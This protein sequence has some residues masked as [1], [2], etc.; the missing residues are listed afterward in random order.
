MKRRIT[1]S[2]VIIPLLASVIFLGFIT[3]C[4]T[5]FIKV[6]LVPKPVKRIINWFVEPPV[7]I[8]RLVLNSDKDRD[9]INDLEDIVKGARKEVQNKPKY[10][11]VYY[12]G[13]YPPQHE[14]VCTDVIW[15]ALENAGY[16]L[17]NLIDKDIRENT[18]DYPRVNGK[19]DPN[20]DFR[21][22]KNLEVFFEKYASGLTVEIRP[23]DIDNLKQW[24]GGDIVVFRSPE[25][26]GI[27]SDKRRRDGVP[28]VLHNGGPYASESDILLSA[29]DKITGHFRFPGK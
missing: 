24:Q 1:P 22:V 27:V 12:K 26:I 7:T 20:I 10:K 14:G 21:R 28:Y 15:R 16:D 18:G 2:V 17:K 3:F 5:V 29:E 19:P 8:E 6:N 25:H 23:R 9:G 13:G 4:N 11:S